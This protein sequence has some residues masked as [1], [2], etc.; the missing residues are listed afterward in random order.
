[1]EN[2]KMPEE[3][4]I[5]AQ[6]RSRRVWQRVVSLL[7]CVVVFC[8]TYALILPAITMERAAV[9]GREEHSHIEE[10]FDVADTSVL[11]CALEEHTHTDECRTGGETTPST[12][13]IPV[14][15]QKRSLRSRKQTGRRKLRGI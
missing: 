1:M 12:E 13:N 4:R 2:R 6:K 8:T 5:V 9:C 7:A 10:C 11:V 3:E 15:P 14:Q